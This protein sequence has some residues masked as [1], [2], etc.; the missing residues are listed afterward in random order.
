ML[1]LQ[2]DSTAHL[3]VFVILD[4]NLIIRICEDLETC[5][6]QIESFSKLGCVTKPSIEKYKVKKLTDFD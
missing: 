2:F 3:E 5:K 1:Y 6:K 4:D